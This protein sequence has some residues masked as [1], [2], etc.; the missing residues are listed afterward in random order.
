MNDATA[1]SNQDLIDRFL[2]AL[3]LGRGSATNTTIAY[4]HDLVSFA[5]HLAAR[6]LLQAQRADVLA[7][8]AARQR[9]GYESRSSARMLS[10][11]RSFYAHARSANWLASD[12]TAHVDSPRLGR[13]LPDTLTE[14]DV[15]ALLAAP[16]VSQPLGLRDRTML[17]LLYA[18]GM[19]VTELT[20]LR[21]DQYSAQ[22]GLVRVFGKGS[23][24]R[25]IPVGDEACNWLARYIS[26]VESAS[27]IFPGRDG[28]AL[29]RQA[30]WHR[31][32]HY[33][34]V[35]DIRK[36]LSPH[37]LR[38]AFAT[39]LLDHGADLRSVQ[40]LLGHAD[41]STTQIYTHVAQARLQALHR[42][43]HPRG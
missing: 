18:T 29:T 14:A 17:E 40:M 25:L 32:K 8:M 3:W 34:Q 24:E 27:F 1:L 35:A 36:H 43:H 30:F 42:A 31:I 15:E 10:A 39:H 12:P 11:L 22:Q 7:F 23:K 2:D 4:R 20:G 38:H 28:A 33:G 6:G 16:D 19:R 13:R 21:R 26:A 41:L 37:T 5:T 9:A